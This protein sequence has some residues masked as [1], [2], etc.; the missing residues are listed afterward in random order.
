MTGRAPKASAVG[1]ALAVLLMVSLSG[2]VQNDAATG[3]AAINNIL[4]DAGSILAD[5]A[6]VTA[7]EGALNVV[8]EGPLTTE[9][10]FLVTIPPGVTRV[11]AIITGTAGIAMVNDATGRIRCQP[12]RYEAYFT[13]FT[14]RSQC[15]GITLLDPLPAVW[16]TTTRNLLADQK[17]ELRL[18]SDPLDGTAATIKIANLSMPSHKEL[19]TEVVTMAASIDGEPIHLEV[20]R[21][22]T[23]EP[24]P[25]IVVSS[26][27]YQAQRLAKLRAENSTIA[28]WVP[29]GFAVV[30]ADVRGFALSGGCIEVWGKNEQQDQVDIVE[31]VA[32]QPWS[33]G[34]VG[35]YGQSYV[36]TTP[37]EAASNAAP[38]LTTI[39]TV[40][41]VINSYEDWHYGGV[42]NGEQTASP[43]L[44]YQLA[45]TQG[46]A[47]TQADVLAAAN[48]NGASLMGKTSAEAL[49]ALAD[50]GRRGLCDPTLAARASDPRAVYDSFYAERDFKAKVGNVKASVLYTQGFYDQNV[51]SQMIPG[52]FNELKVPKKG[53]FGDWIHQHPPR[54][55]QELLFHAWFDYWLK[56]LDTGIMDTPA[57]EVRTNVDTVRYASEWPP[58]DASKISYGLDFAGSMISEG[59]AGKGS[60]QYVARIAAEAPSEVP[61]DMLAAMVPTKLVLRTAPLA[62]P[63]YVSGMVELR[64]NAALTG[65]ENTF[66]YAQLRDVGPDSTR[67]VTFGARN[68]AL[69]EDHKTYTPVTPAAARDYVLAM[70]PTE[71]VVGAGHTLEL[72]I[73]G[74]TDPAGSFHPGEPGVV[75]L[76]GAQSALVFPTLRVPGDT[77]IPLSAGPVTV[78]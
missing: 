27:Y 54:G 35:F 67:V 64:L 69:S 40:A 49:M 56:G 75:T 36:G 55:D 41:P 76:A 8:W 37:V 13:P 25:T 34:K 61:V 66:I 23:S 39:I 21:P 17:I 59:V 18:S 52:W 11:D 70:L 29:R 7:V 73:D 62:S 72:E 14:T 51:K 22:D 77:A 50:Q 26:P 33:S 58:R 4:P 44:G 38:H 42:P 65:A 1:P 28:D 57:V 19:P 71:Y 48:G 3:P 15:T 10:G 63:M 6:V 43:L 12:D 68:A 74:V 30:T 9:R 31:W 20:T 5:K 45:D 16:R 46:R 78:A 32:K 2:C 53:I 47:P 60:A 24:V